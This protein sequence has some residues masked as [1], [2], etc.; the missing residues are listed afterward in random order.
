[1]QRERPTTRFD[2]ID[3]WALARAKEGLIG[4]IRACAYTLPLLVMEG[5]RGSAFI[6]WL[7]FW[8]VECQIRT[9][10]LKGEPE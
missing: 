4:A 1:M 9:H 2:S 8:V 6:V 3:S 5:W 7:T 10:R